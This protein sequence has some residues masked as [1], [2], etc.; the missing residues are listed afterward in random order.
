MRWTRHVALVWV[1][2]EAYTGFWWGHVRERDHLE[3]LGV[4]GGIIL[5]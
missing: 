3:H 1:R 5:R 4:D 2:G